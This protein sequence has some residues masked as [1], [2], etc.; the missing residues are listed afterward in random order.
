MH[1]RR[2]AGF[3]ENFASRQALSPG[4]S[5][6]ANAKGLLRIGERPLALLG[7]VSGET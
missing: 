7:R 1:A 3:G 5:N 2:C 4:S 6:S